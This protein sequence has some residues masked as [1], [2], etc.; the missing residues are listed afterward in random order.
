MFYR[1]TSRYAIGFVPAVLLKYRVHGSNMHG[2]VAAMERDM[3][4]A[5]EKAFRVMT[6]ELFQIKR[7]AYGALH[8]NLA[9]SYFVAGKY[10]QF[11]RHAIRSLAF[12]PGNIVHF[13]KF[14]QKRNGR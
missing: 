6:P 8:Q 2:N 11:I 1:V 13:L 9:G 5:F 10:L 3:T 14:P 4:L 7:Q 12:D